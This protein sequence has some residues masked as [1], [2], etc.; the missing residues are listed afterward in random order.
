MGEQLRAEDSSGDGRAHLSAGCKGQK[1]VVTLAHN[2]VFRDL[3]FDIAR[4]QKKTSAKDF[5]TLGTEKTLD[6]LWEREEYSNMC[7]K[8]GLWAAVA[9]DEAKTPREMEVRGAEH[10][11]E[12][13]ERRFWDK[14][15]DVAC[16]WTKKRRYAMCWSSSEH[17]SVTGVLRNKRDKKRNDSMTIWSGD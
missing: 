2:G 6:S 1:E 3:M 12:E 9:E 8:E 11:E 5:A 4:H 14:R 16:C 17:L 10:R 13:L 15:P 7:S